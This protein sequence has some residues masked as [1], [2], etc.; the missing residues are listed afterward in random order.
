[1]HVVFPQP[2]DSEGTS[3]FN[4]APGK[5]GSNSRSRIP[6]MFQIVAKIIPLTTTGA[7]NTGLDAMEA[8]MKEVYTPALVV[9]PF[10]MLNDIM[11]DLVEWMVRLGPAGLRSTTV[12]EQ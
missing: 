8:G 12:K 3:Y 2:L 4:N 5:A 7:A 6:T 10:R 11:P 1:M 9:L